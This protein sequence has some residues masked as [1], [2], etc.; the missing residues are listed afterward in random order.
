[1]GRPWAEL[2]SAE[3]LDAILLA[4]HELNAARHGTATAAAVAIQVGGEH[5]MELTQYSR[6]G[7]RMNDAVRVTPGITVLRKRGLLTWARRYDGLSGSADALTAAG[8][9]RVRE[10]LRE[11]GGREALARTRRPP[12]SLSAS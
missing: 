10:L 11:R 2:S 6:T 3:R 8:F 9:K 1:V 7:R 12:E 5:R 4:V